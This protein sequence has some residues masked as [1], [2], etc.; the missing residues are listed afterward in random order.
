MDGSSSIDSS[1]LTSPSPLRR[2][3]PSIGSV[4]PLNWLRGST[5]QNDEPLSAR[6]HDEVLCTTPTGPKLRQLPTNED[7]EVLCF[8]DELRLWAVS[9]Y[10]VAAQT[11]R[12]PRPQRRRSTS[13]LSSKMTSA[14]V[15]GYVGT[16]FKDRKRRARTGRQPLACVP[17]IG[18]DAGGGFVESAFRCVD[19]RGLKRDGQ[20]VRIGDA[21]ILQDREGHVWNSTVSGV[22]GYLAPRLR[23][24]RGETRIRFADDVQT[25]RSFGEKPDAGRAVRYG[26]ALHLVT[27]PVSGKTR[28]IPERV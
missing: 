22:V 17:P 16:F 14:D 18:E 21:L 19:P 3:V 20:P 11:Q 1:H 13:D 12:P 26:D 9:E 5:P 25:P 27:C 28:H 24:E 15:G 8:G 4:S 23:G 7:P 10:A 2:R 6:S